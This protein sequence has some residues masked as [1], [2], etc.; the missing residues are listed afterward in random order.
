[1]AKPKRVSTVEKVKVLV[2]KIVARIGLCPK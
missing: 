2:I 1:M